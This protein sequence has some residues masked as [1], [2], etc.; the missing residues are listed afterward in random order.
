MRYRPITSV[1]SCV[2]DDSIRLGG[3]WSNI[4]VVDTSTHWFI[5]STLHSSY[6]LN[7]ILYK[8][9]WCR[10]SCLKH[11]LFYELMTFA[12]WGWNVCLKHMWYNHLYIRDKLTSNHLYSRTLSVVLSLCY[13]RYNMSYLLHGKIYTRHVSL[14]NKGILGAKMILLLHLTSIS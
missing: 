3:W 12:F 4:R 14:N 2:H 1:F 10:S 11:K 13:I 5:S 8:M 9:W 6:K 7:W